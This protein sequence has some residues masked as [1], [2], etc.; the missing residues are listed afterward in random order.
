M[1]ILFE[2]YP[3]QCELDNIFNKDLINKLM[4]GVDKHESNINSNWAR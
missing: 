1:M 2:Y 4:N 3:I